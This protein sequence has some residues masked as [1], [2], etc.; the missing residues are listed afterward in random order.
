MGFT[1]EIDNN[2]AKA[3]EEA[4]A[5]G[6][7]TFPPLPGGKYQVIIAKVK[8]VDNFAKSGPNANKKV[9]NVGFQIVPESP[10]G[11]SRYIWGRVPLFSR[12]APNEKYP[13]GAPARGFWDF[14]EKAIGVPRE[15]ILAGDLPDNIGG[16]RLTVTLSAP[17]PPDQFNP[18]GSNEVDFYDKTGDVNVTP[19]RVAGVSVAPWLDANDNLLP[20]FTQQTVAGA[21][22]A[23]AA[24]P[25]GDPWATQAPAQPAAAAPTNDP[26]APN[27]ADVAYAQQPA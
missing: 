2:A 16:T 22:A 24:A 14:W 20:E 6:N 9:V 13:D 12:F 5:G 7:G 18:L 26:W 4:A 8:G 21:Q 27:A 23:T 15:R 3:A 25:A 19:K 10:T 1:A 17:I 11:K